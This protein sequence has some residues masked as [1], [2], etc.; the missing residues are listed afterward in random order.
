MSF[1]LQFW[2]GRGDLICK[3][4]CYLYVNVL[5]TKVTPIFLTWFE[6]WVILVIARCRISHSVSHFYEE[7]KSIVYFSCYLHWDNHMFCFFITNSLIWRGRIQWLCF[8]WNTC[9]VCVWHSLYTCTQLHCTDVGN[10][11][12]CC[13]VQNIELQPYVYSVLP[14]TGH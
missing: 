11:L 12:L 9:L 14:C 3:C 10:L 6:L 5:L 4:V 7:F 8:N 2:L 13:S 1:S